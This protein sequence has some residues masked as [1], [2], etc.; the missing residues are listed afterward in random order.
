MRS[1]LIVA[2]LGGA[3]L[4]VPASVATAQMSNDEII[5]N[6]MSAAPEAV[7]KNA[8]V[9]DWEMKTVREGTNNFTCLP[10]DPT[11]P[12]DDPICVDENGLGV[13]STPS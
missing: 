4:A 1:A 9:V 11:T 3:A 7:G 6:A 12:S 13:A 5:K 8:T 10:N 2:L